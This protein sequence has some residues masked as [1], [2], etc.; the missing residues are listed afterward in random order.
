MMPHHISTIAHEKGVTILRVQSI[1]GSL[2]HAMMTCN[3]IMLTTQTKDPVISIIAKIIFCCNGNF[4][5]DQMIGSG[6]SR[7]TTS[8][9]AFT[10]DMVMPKALMLR[11]DPGA[12]KSQYLWMGWQRNAKAKAVRREEMIVITI[13]V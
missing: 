8:V 2:A 12:E 3:R 5:R 9:T 6:K 10:A 11:H 13:V 7:S 1:L 4:L